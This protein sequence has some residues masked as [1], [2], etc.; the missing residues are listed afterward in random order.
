MYAP[1]FKSG[2]YVFFIGKSALAAKPRKKAGSLRHLT[3]AARLS[4][5]DVI[6]Y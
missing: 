3:A 6:P 2:A 4:D 1:D 5:L